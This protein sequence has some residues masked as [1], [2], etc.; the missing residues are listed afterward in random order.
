MC[1]LRRC[2]QVHSHSIRHAVCF[3]VGGQGGA[4]R[5]AEM[6]AGRGVELE[7]IVDEVRG[8]LWRGSQG[9]LVHMHV[10]V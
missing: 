8:G 3:Q 10:S 5:V 6:L 9:A 7:L 1:A 4:A 2:L